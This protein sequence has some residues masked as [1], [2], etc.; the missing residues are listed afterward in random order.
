MDDV[1]GQFSPGA[2]DVVG[3]DG[4]GRK[5]VDV[6]KRVEEF[7]GDATESALDGRESSS[8]GTISSPFFNPIGD[9][10]EQQTPGNS[11]RLERDV[12]LAYASLPSPE[13][14][15]KEI[16]PYPATLLVESLI[17]MQLKPDYQMH[18][19]KADIVPLADRIAS[20]GRIL[21]TRGQGTFFEVLDKAQGKIGVVVSFVAILELAK[22][23]CIRF[24]FQHEDSAEMSDLTLVWRNGTD[25]DND[26]ELNDFHAYA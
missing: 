18:H 5:A 16:P 8:G 17:K 26:D 24:Q 12:F 10:V 3:R 7:S 19:I 4:S 22:Q 23:R 6:V 15:A 2:G 14:L 20:I 11:M 21:A 13:V 25:D 1:E 9:V